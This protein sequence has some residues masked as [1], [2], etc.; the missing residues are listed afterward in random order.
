MTN[1]RKYPKTVRNRLTEAIVLRGE[2]K[3]YMQDLHNLEWASEEEIAAY[4]ARE[5]SRVL[6]DAKKQVPYYR[7]RVEGEGL[8]AF[9]I[10][11]R[12]DINAHRDDLIVQSRSDKKT[13]TDITSGTTSEPLSIMLSRGHRDRGAVQK[14]FFNEW[15]GSFLGDRMIKYWVR[16][17]VKTWKAKVYTLLSNGLRNMTHIASMD[18]RAA[19]IE[20]FAALV[21]RVQPKLIEANVN[22]I[23]ECS[24]YLEREQEGMDYSGV[25]MTSTASL[26]PI[27]RDAISRVFQCPVFD[28]YGCREMIDIACDCEKHKGLHA[29]PFMSVMEIVDEDGNP[30]KPGQTGRILMTQLFN[31]V[32]PLIRYEL[33][34]Y[35]TWSEESCDCGRNWPL[36][37]QIDGRAIT[38]FKHRDGGRMAGYVFIFYV[39][40]VVGGKR[41]FKQQ[42]IQEDYNRFL[43]KLV[44][45]DTDPWPERAAHKKEIERLASELIGEP[46]EVNFEVLQEIPNEPSGKF[47]QAMTKIP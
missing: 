26:T 37:K 46:A 28:R 16:F 44:M 23:Y 30:C 1:S 20:E 9:P 17:P 34:D 40:T 12:A 35:G 5:L 14:I 13:V 31:P 22:A 38:M 2:R 15:A 36:I 42:I 18:L 11:S 41:V 24:L 8:S 29:S 4:Q 21:Q 47:L 32:M 39:N 6:E 33:G 45:A 43:I 27:K 10:L 25:I 3:S 19:K 7:D